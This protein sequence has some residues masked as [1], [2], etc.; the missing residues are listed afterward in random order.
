[1]VHD[2]LWAAAGLGPKQMAC[3]HCLAERLGRPLR[4][5]DFV[6]A[7]VNREIVAVLEANEAVIEK[8]KKNSTKVVPH[9]P[10]IS[11]GVEGCG[12]CFL[13]SREP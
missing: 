12:T 6:P 2:E 10:S 7:P 13:L 1:M 9:E 3:L 11:C 5:A 4:A 8:K